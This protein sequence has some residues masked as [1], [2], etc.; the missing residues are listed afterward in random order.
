MENIL[1]TKSYA[2]DYIGSDPT[3]MYCTFTSISV[4][5]KL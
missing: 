2:I 5:V 3:G 4:Q 1:K